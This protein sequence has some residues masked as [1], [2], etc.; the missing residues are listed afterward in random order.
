M[1]VAAL[2]ELNFRGIEVPK[3]LAILGFDNNEIAEFSVPPLSSI[4]QPVNELGREAAN[5]LVNIIHQK[6]PCVQK[7]S[8]QSSFVQRLSTL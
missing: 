5:L 1:A 7:R 3:Q 4:S 6:S 2:N 8:I